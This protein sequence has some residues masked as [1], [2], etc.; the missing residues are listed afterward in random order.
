MI[1]KTYD[2]ENYEEKETITD[3][4]SVIFNRRFYKVGSFEIHTSSYSFEENDIIAYIYNGEVRSGIVMKIVENEA[5]QNDIVVSGYDMKGIYEFRYAT[6]EKKY[7]GT[8]SEILKSI[9]NDFFTT[10]NRAIPNFEISENEILG[11]STSYELVPGHISKNIEE[12]SVL[13]EVGSDVRFDLSKK[14]TFETLKGDDKSN[15]IKFGRMFQNIESTEYVKDLFNTYNVGY[16]ENENGD[17]S[18]VG[19]A[20]GLKRREGYSKENINEYLAE[21]VESETIRGE[22]N[23]KY[24]YG[25]DYNLGD[26]VTVISRGR[27]TKKQITEIK[28]VFERNKVLIVPIFGTEKEN[29]IKKLFKGVWKKWVKFHIAKLQQLT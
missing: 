8:P 24:K 4:T 27:E 17:I 15:Y 19:T 16:S 21:H 20:S 9:I 10:E 22:A 13:H 3:L 5:E 11:D 25:I 7:T 1:I 2:P 26:Y 28:E 6:A 29:P 14:V 18:V 23:D 12:F